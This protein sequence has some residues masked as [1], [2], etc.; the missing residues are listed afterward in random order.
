[1]E[2]FFST[3]YFKVQYQAHIDEIVKFFRRILLQLEKN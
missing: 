3:L 2:Q 1:M